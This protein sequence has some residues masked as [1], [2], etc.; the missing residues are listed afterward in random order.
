ME[1][2]SSVRNFIAFT[3]TGTLGLLMIPM[4]LAFPVGAIYWLWIAIQLGS[5]T[6]FFLGVAGPFAILTAPIGLWSLM[7]G[8]PMWVINLFG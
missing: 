8:T 3:C 4:F 5:F 1:L 6:M 2:G 7:F